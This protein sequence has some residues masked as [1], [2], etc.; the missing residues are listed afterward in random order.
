ME[1]SV[2]RKKADFEVCPAGTM[3]TLATTRRA[4]MLQGKLLRDLLKMVQRP[5]GQQ[6]PEA[7]RRARKHT[8]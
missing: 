6:E 4:L 7:V 2:S 1:G 5:R 3:Q 8:R